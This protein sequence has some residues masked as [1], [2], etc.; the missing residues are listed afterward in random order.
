MGNNQ[1]NGTAKKWALFLGVVVLIAIVVVVIIL[2]IPPN[3]YN[4]VET[5]N[6]VS[7][8][9]YL[10]VNSEQVEFDD[11]KIKMD[12]SAVNEYSKEL[13]DIE[14]LA[15]SIDVILD[16][17]NDYLVF[18]KDNKN[19]KESYKDIKEGLQNAKQNQKKMVEIVAKTNEL[20][21]KSATYLQGA[22]IDY[23]NEFAEY[24]SHISRAVNGLT[25]AY[26]GSMGEVAFN[27]Q[28][29]KLI[30]NTTSEYLQVI[31]ENFESLSKTDVKGGNI[32]TYAEKYAELGLTAKIELFK[33]FV[34]K[35]IL[36][37]GDIKDYYFN[38]L[39]Q[40]K[41]DKFNQFFTLYNEENLTTLIESMKT[42]GGVSVISKTYPD[43][44]D[45]EGVYLAICE[46]V[47]GGI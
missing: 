4:A 29:S 10:T 47:K 43:V 34:E 12:A 2:A 45:T 19:L 24:I 5:L 33:A 26:N 13:Y 44:V 35:N 25:K 39:I 42:F 36:N 40:A 9:S 41:Y 38:Q 30:L 14:D 16:Y 37:D 11:F 6:Q 20:S 8:S 28:A 3:A 46:F 27:N 7:Q 32:T 21:D 15:F 23:R 18:A 22:M 31:A 1:G 17:H